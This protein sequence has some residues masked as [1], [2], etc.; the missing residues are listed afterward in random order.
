MDQLP[1]T[2]RQDILLLCVPLLMKCGR[3]VVKVIWELLQV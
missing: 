1:T 2:M 3:K